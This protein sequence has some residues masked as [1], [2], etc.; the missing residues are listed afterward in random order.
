MVMV[1]QCGR[2]ATRPNGWVLSQKSLQQHRYELNQISLA[3]FT[4]FL[5]RWIKNFLNPHIAGLI[6]L[7]HHLTRHQFHIDTYFVLYIYY[8]HLCIFLFLVGWL[9]IPSSGNRYRHK[10]SASTGMGLNSPYDVGSTSLTPVTLHMTPI[11]YECWVLTAVIARAAHSELVLSL[12]QQGCCKGIQPRSI[13]GS[14]TFWHFALLI[15]FS[16]W[17]APHR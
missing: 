10:F 12:V 14:E 16:C 17:S 6:N 11:Y 5:F 15:V 9:R 1:P 3:V 7:L 4:P 8:N 13:M 2:V